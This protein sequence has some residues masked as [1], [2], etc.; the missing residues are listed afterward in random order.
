M[1]APVIDLG[2]LTA[3]QGFIIQGD[4]AGDYAGRSVSSAGDINGDGFAD[5]IV[6]ASG[7]DNGGLN[8]GE[9]YVI[10]GKTG[11]TRTN[12]DLSTL[13]ASDG[14]IIQG[15]TASNFAGYSV[16]SAG[17]I[18]GDGF[19]DLIVG[20]P[21][22]SSGGTY[23]GAAYV[24][25]G[26]AGGTRTN[27]D[28]TA[29]AASDGFII[30]GDVAGDQAGRSVSSAGDIN[31]DGFADL[32]IG[33]PN[34]DNGGSA[35]GEAYVVFGKAGATSTNI[36]LTA[37]AASDGFIIQGDAAFD[38]AGRSVSSAGD[39][40]GDGFA[41]LIVGAARG[42]NGGTNAGEA[43]V[44]F[45]KA[46]AT[47][48]DID[49]TALAASDGFIIQGDVAGDQAGYSVSS[50]GDI[51]GDGFADLIVG[52]LF[53]DDGGTNAG[54]AYII[55]GKAG[56][57]RTNIDLTSL[58]ASD[59]FIIQGD[60]AY[61]VAGFSISSAGDINGDGFADL[62]VGAP[63]ADNNGSAA[64]EAYVIFG[65]AGATRTDIDL[66]ALAASNGFIIRG[67]L[68]FDAA[69]RSVSSAGDI[70]GDGFADLIV[71]A[72]NGANGGIR[73]GEAYVIYG[74]AN[75][76]S[77]PV[78]GDDSL[79]ADP[80]Q[81]ATYASFQLLRNDSSPFTL[82]VSAVSNA[83]GG[84][85]VLNADKTISF[86]LT[87]GFT[88]IAGFDYIASD[89]AQGDTGRVTI[90]VAAPVAAKTIDLTG[91][92]AAQG[93]IIEGDVGG[94]QA[95]RSVSS[96]GDIN[97]D[98]FADL[99]VGAPYGDNGGISAGEA[100][101]IFG[102]AGANRTNIDLT[103]LAASDG[104]VIQGDVAGDRAGRSVA[105]AGDINGDGFA[106][107]IVGAPY[108][109][110][111]GANAGEAYVIFGKAGATRTNIDLTSLVASD[112]FFIQGDVGG[113][114]AGV[115][116]ASAGDINGDGFADL[117]VGASGGDNGGDRAGEAYVIFGK[118]GAT[119]ANIDLTSLAASDGF[120]IQGD[121]AYD[122]TG[123]SVSSA[124]DINGDGI[125]DLIVGAH[126]GDNGGIDAGE[127][128]V[129]FG[130][131]GA[132]RANIDLTSL[133]ASDGFVIQ[134]DAAFDN[135]GWSVSSA[136]DINGDG[137]ADLIVGAPEGSYGGSDAGEA[138]VIYGKAGA[139]RANIDL[140]SLPA[141][142]GFVIHGDANFDRA[143]WSVSSAGDINGDG[144]ADL[145]VG[146]RLGGNGGIAAGE[147]YVIFGK[148]GASRSN[149]DLTTLAA[150]DGFIIQGDAAGDQAGYSVASAGDI[151]GDGFADLIVGAPNGDNGGYGAGEAYVIYGRADIGVNQAPTA[152]PVT[153]AAIAEDSG[154]RLITTAELLAGAADTDGPALTITAF[155]LT[156]GNGTLIDNGNGTWSYIAAAN[157]DTAAAFA[158]TVSDS[159][160]SASSTASLDITPVNDAPVITSNGGSAAASVSIAENST[161]VTTVTSTDADVGATRAFSIAGGADALRFR[162][163][164]TTGALSFIAAP[165]FESP[166]DVGGNNVYNVIVRASDG[167]LSD[168]QAIAIT[169]TDVNEIFTGQAGTNNTF[170]GT[171]GDDTFN[172]TVAN[173][174]G[175]DTLTGNG[176]TDTLVL[177]GAGA[178]SAASL[179]G[180]TSVEALTFGN[181]GIS[182]TFSDAVANANGAILAV[183][184]S[185]GN[186]TLDY[187]AV[188]L[189]ARSFNVVAGAG[190]DI[191]R[192]GAGNDVFRFN[193]LDLTAA[194]TV[195]GGGGT[196]DQLIF[197]TAGTITAASLANVGGIERVILA[198]GTNDITL[199][200]AMGAS[201]Q[202]GLI[203]VFGTAG[204]DR[205]SATLLTGGARVDVTAG[206]GL[207]TLLGTA[208]NDT[209]RFAGA[210][211]AGDT[212]NGGAGYD[213]LV[214]STADVLSEA[215]LAL[216]SNIDQITLNVAGSSLTLDNAVAAANAG[217][218]AV[219][220]S[221]GNDTVDAS[222]VT[223][224]RA[225]SVT[226][227][228]GND[229]LRGGTGNDVFRFNAVDLTAADTV[230]G[231]GGIGIDAINFQTAG[232]I[233]AA[234]LA[235]VSGIERIA[236][237]AGTNA[238][239]L[240]DALLNTA[241][242][243]AMTVF[244][245]SGD[246]TVDGSALTGANKL[247][248]Y[249]GLGNDTLR[250]G[251][252][253]D[254]FR[255]SVAGLDGSDVVAG[256]AGFDQLNISTAGALTAAKLAGVSGIEQ[257]VLSIPGVALT[258][259][260]AVA[261][262][263]TATLAVFASSS[264]DIIDAS[265][266]TDTTRGLS[267]TA[268]GGN[269]NFRGGLGTDTFRFN[270]ADLTSLDTVQGGGG[271]ANDGIVFLTA[272]TV[273]AA[274]FTQVSEIETLSFAA[275]GNAVTLTNA[276]V[277]SASA[278]MVSINGSEGNDTVNAAAVT[279]AA[280]RITV[281]A[282][283]GSDT[284]TGGAGNDTI[285]GGDGADTL[286]GG[287]GTDLFV[288]RTRYT[289]PDAILDFLGAADRLQF[290]ASAFDFNG[291]AF[292]QRLAT[293]S[294]ATDITGQDLVIYTGSNLNSVG[295]VASYLGSAAGGSSGEGVF[296]LGQDSS[297]QTVLY[298]A[299]DA[300]FT[301]STDIVEVADLGALTAPNAIQLSD[302][303][304]I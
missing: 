46:G 290:T 51:N 201:A 286:T 59:G 188:T 262:A 40:N 87:A 20:A 84:T 10:F 58:A 9:A 94:D 296:I 140:T 86:T 7:G 97:G 249:T 222:A 11:G 62:I 292:D 227:N 104:F 13:A 213:N 156:S 74:R 1:A 221:T 283:A 27:I 202:G 261:A 132:S 152:A 55:F 168:T 266:V 83:T 153:L 257:I 105:S 57:I 203:Q 107:L 52:A 204:N 268:L 2:L 119:R 134:G 265:A 95:G 26:K 224:T 302:F 79:R 244:T 180:M 50:A 291:A 93:F 277:G 205:V 207:D 304:F 47:R 242:S 193:A 175:A 184:G 154:V 239:T 178:V 287:G 270:A 289:A 30:Q 110:N 17:D 139:T 3:A 89:G 56:S 34:G 163:N 43:Y 73:A 259:N 115:S 36:D 148:A 122:T 274:A 75:F 39:I 103:S 240:T 238:I 225:I 157:D 155:T 4:V 29:L 179:A 116:V 161:A 294:A 211:L 293:N 278:T 111:G 267:V 16:A 48:T 64:G 42:D 280:N 210:D 160:L 72:P 124:G 99:I 253:A 300:S 108:G 144:F 38:E 236:L 248:I 295:D 185:L 19:A 209:F 167:T 264:N 165:D 33:S 237:A 100:Y 106:D 117:I 31:G 299:L 166:T 251:A 172:F 136:G 279:T 6:G 162:I 231:G 70:N 297:G 44:I 61:D 53:G 177:T 67:D 129:I 252:G 196:V 137:F 212:V 245:N 81:I 182:V 21:L 150:S 45:G 32:I 243:N 187:S 206:A 60:V 22:S 284:L 18:N 113:D 23:A 301:A 214:I 229:T 241:S 96:A 65:K 223:T 217:V 80:N 176:G 200:A 128:Y 126:D 173:L 282:G 276:L 158:Y 141:S 258:L 192:G 88:G 149:I 68:E 195:A 66:T 35:A 37:L 271:T 181:G 145:I 219:F 298:H 54:E 232:T 118:A 183:T 281:N 41:D 85:V 235:A 24:I 218:L 263:N 147:A 102:K 12:I 127:A 171:A 138:Y 254:I 125:A 194:D 28:L 15:D 228:A 273:S 250:G 246:D 69:G 215:D 98:G 234:N 199:S 76:G 130:K 208:G 133:A 49:L 92:T 288:W 256:G 135:A 159:S 191:L 5:L 197:E 174:T 146:A 272:G 112:G 230:A 91:L 260:N 198:N 247:E 169:V 63:G 285:E 143:G 131:A 120:I 8:A 275:G 151:N 164:A 226:A 190:N 14:F 109:A 170:I 303:V 189:A 233:T 269:D 121:V 123:F 255:F 186:D 101:V 220:G 25:F 71:G 78:A 82:T 142:D 114:Y 77:A 216:V 90:T